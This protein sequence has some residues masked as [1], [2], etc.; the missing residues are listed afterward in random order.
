MAITREQT[1]HVTRL[2]RLEIAE[3]ELERFA[4]QI[5]AVL[6]YVE[7]LG[8]VDTEG[9]SPTFHAIDLTNAFREDRESGHLERDGSLA[10]APLAE[11]GFFV[12]P[13]VVG[14]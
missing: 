13:K 2:A 1:E 4:R 12:V 6:E 10:N 3:E 8:Q 9:V 7:T 14:G 11:A 5:G